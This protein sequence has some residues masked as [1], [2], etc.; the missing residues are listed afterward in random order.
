VT[1]CKI[2]LITIVTLALVGAAQPTF[3]QTPTEEATK[4]TLDRMN[5]F[6]DEQAERAEERQKEKK[7]A[8]QRYCDRLLSLPETPYNCGEVC[9]NRRDYCNSQGY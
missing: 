7:A 3:A 9:R 4:E 6:L 1:P 2:A 5:R 8:E